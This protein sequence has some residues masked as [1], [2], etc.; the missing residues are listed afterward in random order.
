MSGQ[1]IAELV[2]LRKEFA[3]SQGLFATR[4]VVAVDDVN[5]ALEA[6]ESVGIVGESGSGKST[7]GRLLLG[8][9]APS[10]GKVVIEGKEIATLTKTEMRALRRHV[11]IVFQNPHTALHPRMMVSRALAE[12]LRIQGDL[13]H[14]EITARV[15]RMVDTIGL[16]QSFLGRY[17]HELSGGQKQRICIARAL[18][19]NPRIIVLDE[20]TSALDVSVQAQILE[21]LQSL[22]EEFGL[23]YLFISHDLAVV[24][25][26][27]TRVLVM[28][29][30]R[31]VDQG[32]TRDILESPSHPYTRR[33]LAATLEPSADAALPVISEADPASGATTIT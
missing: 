2:A 20:P 16:P 17:P 3:V 15:R 23:T 30:G 24:Q 28:Y 11:Q 4:T 13:S 18:I 5:L 12:P 8:L 33:L 9:V 19:L 22:R 26:M 31:I 29:R 7:V 1:P 14:Q 32:A 6:G 25:A 27:C 21:F 10:A